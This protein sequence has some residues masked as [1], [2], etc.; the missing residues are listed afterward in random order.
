MTDTKIQCYADV[1][2]MQV[3]NVKDQCKVSRNLS[4]EVPRGFA[5]IT[6]E[7]LC[8]NQNVGRSNASKRCEFAQAL[9]CARRTLS[10]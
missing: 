10:K 1:K 7:K 8:E 6:Q 2:Q 3:P 4:R 5:E 9:G